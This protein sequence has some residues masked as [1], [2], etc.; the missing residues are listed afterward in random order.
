MANKKLPGG[1]KSAGRVSTSAKKLV[2]LKAGSVGVAISELPEAE[3]LTGEERFPVVQDKETRGASV[4][5]IK[6]LIPSGKDGASAYEAWSKAQAEGSDTS[7]AAFLEYMHGKDGEDGTKITVEDITAKNG[8]IELSPE[9]YWVAFS[10]SKNS[11]FNPEHINAAVNGTY[12]ITAGNGGV[13]N[14]KLDRWNT[15]FNARQNMRILFQC[16]SG[17][18]EVFFS[19]PDAGKIYFDDGTLYDSQKIKFTNDYLVFEIHQIP[20]SSRDF[21]LK[22]VLPV[23]SGS[24]GLSAYEVWVNA[25]EHEADTSLEAYLAFQEGKEGKS[26]YQIWLDEGNEGS[27]ADYLESLK[28]TPGP[29]AY[30][31]WL[32]LGNTGTEED[33]IKSLS[34]SVKTYNQGGGFGI[35]GDDDIS[36]DKAHGFIGNAEYWKTTVPLTGG[37]SDETA[38]AVRVDLDTNRGIPCDDDGNPINYHIHVGQVILSNSSPKV[39][40]IL[41]VFGQATKLLSLKDKTLTDI[42]EKDGAYYGPI[43]AMNYQWVY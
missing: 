24:D 18:A 14:V 43:Y 34:P 31:T 16:D 4:E 39:P 38:L 25:Q 9:S 12:K 1:R 40:L 32:S 8:N 3:N 29:S 41:I 30:E 37:P 17:E 15:L 10:S 22:Q 13:V 36:Q 35:S 28:G 26:A 7:E 23:K 21:I 27:E 5:Q 11:V 20:S 42:G 6:E 2:A 33:F 19:P